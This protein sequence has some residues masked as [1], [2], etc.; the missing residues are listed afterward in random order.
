[1]RNVIS[2]V[3]MQ[4]ENLFSLNKTFLAMIGISVLIPFVIPEMA[5]YA[6]G[7][8]VIALTN[9]TVGREKACNIDNL[10]RTL[11]VKVNEYILSRY[12]FG[13]IGILISIGIMS[14]VALL[15]KGSPYISVESVVISA[16][17]IGS[18]VVG[19]ITPIVTILGPERGKIV[20]IILTVLPLMFTMKLP[21]L[22]S[23]IN[24][25]LLNKNIVF[26]LI[27]LVTILIMYISYL[28]TVNIYK[29]VEL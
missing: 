6:V 20:V 9:I 25:N 8:I 7:I 19:I 2:L 10:V 24:I 5:T 11:P 16:L 3:K 23:D 12:V 1:M 27:M 4:F 17:V 18:V 26:L 13:A 14:I 15:L 29:R 21:E 28:V 22:L